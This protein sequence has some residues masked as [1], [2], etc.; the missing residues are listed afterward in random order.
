MTKKYLF[1]LILLL[2]TYSTII[3][4]STLAKKGTITTATNEKIAFLNLQLGNGKFNYTEVSSGLQKDITISDTKYIED[5]NKSRVFSNKTV[6]ERTKDADLKVEEEEKKLAQE[7]NA[8]L[9]E[10]YT[11]KAAI[12]VRGPGLV[13]DGIYSSKEDFIKGL[14]SSTDELIAKGFIGFEKP[15]LST[16]E[17]NCFF[18]DAK[19]DEKIKR[20]FAI[21][22][23]GH[24]YFQIYAIL[25]HRNKTDRAQTNDFP[26]SFVRVLNA[27]V[28]YY[29]LE[30]T[31]VNQ[32]SQALAYNGGI[33]G[34]AIEGSLHHLKGVVW[35]IQNQEFNIFKN[36]EDYNEFI[37]DKYPEGVQPCD[38]NQP[39]LLAI[40]KAIEKIK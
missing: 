25:D 22:Y 19:T 35:D 24:L 26:N 11:K 28:H 39:D 32:W 20:V 10:E 8:K 33:V 27:G 21:C 12:N 7:K 38:K 23:K 2:L 17:D 36:C 37:K 9:F 4:Q 16:L 18:Y 13:P 30:A 1:G 14:P 40:R 5:E 3:A 6:I 34:G 29:Y 31:L 15:V